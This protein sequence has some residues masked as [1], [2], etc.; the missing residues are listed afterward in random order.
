MNWTEV[1]EQISIQ[2]ICEC[3]FAEGTDGKGQKYADN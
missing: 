2:D 1:L 3:T